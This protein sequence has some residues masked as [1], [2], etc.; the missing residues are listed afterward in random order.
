LAVPDGALRAGENDLAPHSNVPPGQG[1]DSST[2]I[3]DP[4]EIEAIMKKKFTGLEAIFT[5]TLDRAVTAGEIPADAPT[6][7]LAA[8]LVSNLHGAVVNAKA[9]AS[10]RKIHDTFAIALSAVTS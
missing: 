2:T 1:S 4:P 10:R 9:G 5:A 7:K 3:K 6:A 8:F